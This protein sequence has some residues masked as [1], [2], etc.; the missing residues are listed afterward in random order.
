VLVR[1]YNKGLSSN[2]KKR[3]VMEVDHVDR[4]RKNQG[5]RTHPQAKT[6]LDE[7]LP[8]SAKMA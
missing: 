8:I 5:F 7:W 3:L 1:H 2:S 6:K 4:N